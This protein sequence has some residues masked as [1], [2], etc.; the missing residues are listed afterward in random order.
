[1]I[2]VHDVSKR[3]GSRVVLEH[4]TLEARGSRVTALVGPNGS[5]KTTLIKM[6][7]GLARPDR[8]DVR[9]FGDPVDRAGDY[10]RSI[11]YMPQIA[12]FP[13]NLRGVDVIDIVRSL[14]PDAALDTDLI[15]RFTLGGELEKPLGAL[16]GGTRQKVNATVAFLFQPRVLILDE[17]TAGL[18]P[19]A[20]R[21]LKDKI[22]S[23]RSMGAAILITSHILTELEEFADDVAFLCDGVFRYAGPVNELLSRTGHDRLEPAIAALLEN[24]DPF[25]LSRRASTGAMLSLVTEGRR[26]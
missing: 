9:L 19:V 20:S 15:D 25:P 13:E 2:S 26:A 18:D 7:L 1:M 3:Y 21:V 14:R 12:R 5:G 16:S 6:M 22:R 8:G 17:P 11:G 24:R 4:V 23:A 10:R